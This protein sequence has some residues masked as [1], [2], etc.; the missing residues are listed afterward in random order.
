MSE[1]APASAASRWLLVVLVRLPVVGAAL[2]ALLLGV[3]AAAGAD[4]WRLALLALAL[5]IAA[6]VAWTY[7]GAEADPRRLPGP[8]GAVAF[9]ATVFTVQTLVILATGGL[10]SPLPII[11]VPTS[12]FVAVALG[13]RRAWLTVVAL[14]LS[15]LAALAVAEIA[16]PERSLALP[17]FA[18]SAG[19]G[20]R[21]ASVGFF[22]G[23]VA[24]AV[25]IGG[26]LGDAMRVRLDRAW[27]SASASQRALADHLRDR[28]AELVGLAGAIAHELKNP[29]AAISGLSVLLAKR[30]APG[31]REAEQLDV[32]VGEA[33]RMA[34]V[35]EEF[36][37]F[38]RPVH[39]LTLGDTPLAPLVRDVAAAHEGLAERAGVR[40]ALDLADVSA[41]CDPRKLRQVLQNLLQNALEASPPGATVTVTLAPDG[42]D[43]RLGVR[44]AGPG[45]S[46]LVG[47]PFRPGATTKGGG[48]GLGLTVARAIAE[49]HG[50]ALALTD[51]PGG[52]ALAALT[53]PRGG[54]PDAA[55]PPAPA[56]G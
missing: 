5:A 17:L 44:D 38:S 52:G 8:R 40:V 37:N 2:A 46:P 6:S 41:R 43:L 10:L 50:G 36:L 23:L 19:D 51:A 13:R 1:H 28:N 9:A 45:L 34:R 48:S 32:L 39:P 22:A 54:P 12:L 3:F 31:S 15:T 21:A 24:L 27:E 26:A 14:P 53:L 20:S 7:R 55:P 42:A 35:L 29:L 30:A 4:P 18:L 47:D 33:R 16:A 25:L 56:G 11:Y 49:Q